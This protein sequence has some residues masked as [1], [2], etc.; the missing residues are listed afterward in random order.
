MSLVAI[1][2]L[3]LTAL[4]AG[5]VPSF[6]FFGE[7]VDRRVLIM[8]TLATVASY[9]PGLVGLPGLV[10]LGVDGVNIYP[11]WAVLLAF[12][13]GLVWRL[14]LGARRPPPTEEERNAEIRARARA[15][16]E[17]IRNRESSR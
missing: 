16:A 9:T 12:P 7:A 13:I 2:F 14:L 3:I 8:G 4:L 5:F 11:I 15:R 1:G 10:R 17:E 6:L